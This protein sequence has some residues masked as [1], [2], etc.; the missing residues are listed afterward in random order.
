[1]ITGSPQFPSED[2]STCPAVCSWASITSLYLQRTNKNTLPLDHDQP[3]IISFCIHIVNVRNQIQPLTGRWSLGLQ[4]IQFNFQHLN[5]L[6]TIGSC[7]YCHLVYPHICV[8]NKPVKNWA[9]LI[10]R[11]M[12]EKP[13]LVASLCELSDA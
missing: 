1:M 11:T 10:K 6:D 4:Y 8:Q 5:A 2:L 9:K 13:P 12:K 3:L 7:H